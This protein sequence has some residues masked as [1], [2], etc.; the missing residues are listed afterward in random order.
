MKCAHITL[1]LCVVAVT[2]CT[3]DLSAQSRVIYPD[4]FYRYSNLQSTLQ[5]I[6]I[7][8]NGGDFSV[9]YGDE[10]VSSAIQHELGGNSPTF[11]TIN[12]PFNFS[13]YLP[14][15]LGKNT[16]KWEFDDCNY[17]VI[18]FRI[19]FRPSANREVGEYLIQQRCKD[20]RKVVRFEYADYFGLQSFG[21]G[22]VALSTTGEL[23]FIPDA[24]YSLYGANIGFGARQ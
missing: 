12:H 5:N 20:D 16:T 11:L 6:D 4:E 1:A 15:G 23:K 14:S 7:I 8:F 22:E 3:H 24:V 2:G 19:G 13:F 9:V 18:N 10:E 21:V 17:E